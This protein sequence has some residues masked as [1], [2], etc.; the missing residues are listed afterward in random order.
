FHMGSLEIIAPD[1]D[2]RTRDRLRSAWKIQPGAVYDS[3]YSRQYMVDSRPLLP[4]GSTWEFTYREEM[5]DQKK[6]VNLTILM[7]PAGQSQ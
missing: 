6:I 5:D 4:R 1:L 2:S 7:K 3:S